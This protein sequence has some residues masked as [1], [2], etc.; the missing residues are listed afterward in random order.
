M[1]SS[2]ALSTA[3]SRVAVC[4][5]FI[6]ILLAHIH[7]ELLSHEGPVPQFR[8]LL[9]P[10]FPV[11]FIFLADPHPPFLFPTYPHNRR[12]LLLTAPVSDS[13]FSRHCPLAAL[14]TCYSLPPTITPSAT[15][16]Y[17]IRL[18]MHSTASL[19]TCTGHIL[20]PPPPRPKITT[21]I[22]IVRFFFFRK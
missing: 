1:A 8:P 18:A 5:A 15:S 10:T 9:S 21:T 3:K 6:S 11:Y 16:A 14:P 12:A 22:T 13:H 4:A 7:S 2:E 20:L 19:P 17:C